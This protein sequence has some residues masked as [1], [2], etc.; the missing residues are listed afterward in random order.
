MLFLQYIETCSHGTSWKL[1]VDSIISEKQYMATKCSSLD[2]LNREKC[3]GND[4]PMGEQTPSTARGIYYIET[5]S[6]FTT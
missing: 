5:Q 6:P 3:K 1:F 2:F 4:I